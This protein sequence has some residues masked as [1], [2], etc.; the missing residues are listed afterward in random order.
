MDPIEM[1]LG[2]SHEPIRCIMKSHFDRK[3][4]ASCGTKVVVMETKTGVAV[5]NMFNTIKDRCN[6]YIVKQFNAHITFFIVI[7]TKHYL[8]LRISMIS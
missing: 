8:N 6:V 3:L 7:W 4:I 2:E 5:E 1:K